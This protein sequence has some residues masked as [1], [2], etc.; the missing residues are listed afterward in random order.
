MNLLIRR[1]RFESD[2]SHLTLKDTDQYKNQKIVRFLLKNTNAGIP[3]QI[4]VKGSIE[5]TNAEL[6]MKAL[7]TLLLLLLLLQPEIKKMMAH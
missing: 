5:Q 3:L 6:I 1:Q 7:L 4:T 2:A